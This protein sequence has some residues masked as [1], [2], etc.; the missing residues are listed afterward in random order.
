MFVAIRLTGFETC[1]TRL[2]TKIQIQKT[3]R[4]GNEDDRA[5]HIRRFNGMP[6]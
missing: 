3:A 5:D 6:T 1:L 4:S 2:S